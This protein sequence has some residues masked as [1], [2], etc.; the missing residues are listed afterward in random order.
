MLL[1]FSIARVIGRM[2]SLSSLSLTNSRREF[3]FFF[4]GPPRGIIFSEKWKKILAIKN[5]V[6]NEMKSGHPNKQ[7]FSLTFRELSG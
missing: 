4:S 5:F 3:F 1:A 2:R 6:V 7:L